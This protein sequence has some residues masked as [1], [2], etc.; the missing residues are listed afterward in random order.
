[1]LK[2]PHVQER[3]NL[4][5][6]WAKSWRRNGLVDTKLTLRIVFNRMLLKLGMG[7][8]V[9]TYIDVEMPR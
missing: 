3:L 4:A 9:L 8:E 6:I 5:P 2:L 7:N 1:M